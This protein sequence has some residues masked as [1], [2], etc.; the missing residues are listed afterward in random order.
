MLKKSFV[1]ALA[2]GMA[3]TSTVASAG[4]EKDAVIN[5]FENRAVNTFGNC[6]RTK[7]DA[8]EDVCAPPAPEPAPAPVVET[9][10]PPPPEPKI[11]AT[12][13]ERTVYF[14]FDS[15]AVSAEERQKLVDLAGVI[16][17]SRTISNVRAVGY[18]DPFGSSEYNQKLSERRVKAVME[19]LQPLINRPIQPSDLS[20]T[21]AGEIPTTEECKAK[22]RKEQIAC[23]REQRRVEIVLDRTYVE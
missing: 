20:L 18:A 12:K 16:N 21:A 8:G 1:M 9:P 13:A 15:A 22:P 19:V 6:V 4:S 14:D 7:W 3:L 5:D 11:L 17:N 10:P 23:M 2:A